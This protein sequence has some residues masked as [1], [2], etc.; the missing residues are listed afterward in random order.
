MIKLEIYSADLSTEMSKPLAEGLRAGF[1]SPAQDYVSESIDL[2]KDLV[3]NA[4]TTFYARVTGDS[5]KG[6]GIDEGDLIVIDKSLEPEDGDVVVAFLDGDFTLKRVKIDKEDKCVWLMPENEKYK[7][8][9]INE[10][11]DFRIWGVVTYS[12]K[13]QSR[14]R[15]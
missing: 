6:S 10:A 11:E 3:K 9:R 1:P 12:I 14:K 4:A 15:I 8:I 13:K 5:M 2:N 7:P